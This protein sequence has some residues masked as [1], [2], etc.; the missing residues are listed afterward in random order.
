MQA[1]GAST[2]L[3]YQVRFPV[4]WAA[5]EAAREAAKAQSPA[6]AKAKKQLKPK[7]APAVERS[8]PAA[9]KERPGKHQLSESD[10]EGVLSETAS[11]PP[12]EPKRQRTASAAAGTSSQPSV[13]ILG[14][15]DEK[16]RV[17]A[18]KLVTILKVTLSEKST[19]EEYKTW[20]GECSRAAQLIFGPT[21]PNSLECL[22]SLPTSFKGN[23]NKD[24]L[25][26]RT[27]AED[28]GEPYPEAHGWLHI[29][30][31]TK[32]QLDAEVIDE[33]LTGRQLMLSGKI[34]QGEASVT[35]YI[36]RLN[37]ACMKIT[38]VNDMD[39]IVWFLNGLCEQLT[40]VCVCDAMGKTWTCFTTLKRHAL[41]KE[42][43]RNSRLKFAKMARPQVPFAVKKARFTQEK[44]HRADHF[45]P[46][47]SHH[48]LAYTKVQEA[49]KDFKDVGPRG[50]IQR[51][52]DQTQ[53]PT[54]A[55]RAEDH[56]KG[57]P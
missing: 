52:G 4:D 11:P 44:A 57:P 18:S 10:E 19:A 20:T 34:K 9:V 15:D 25:N 55:G 32:T 45:I 49:N 39:R 48:S 43:E 8:A 1:R 42:M 26:L 7:S 6:A 5:G 17:K 35:D 28:A 41:A 40:H 46:T 14:N 29:K 16:E 37:R 36:N 53:A 38:N 23:L 3:M 24:W 2:H 12:Q 33:E 27:S 30:N 13:I 51:T 31:W 50:K 22:T 21:W 47:T 56:F 54:R